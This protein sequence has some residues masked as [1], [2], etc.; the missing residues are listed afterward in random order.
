MQ[1]KDRG[2]LRVILLWTEE[3]VH[4]AV[5]ANVHVEASQASAWMMTQVQGTP[6]PQL[7][8]ADFPSVPASDPEKWKIPLREEVRHISPILTEEIMSIECIREKTVMVVSMNLEGSLNVIMVMTM[9]R[10]I[11]IPLGWLER[12]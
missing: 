12:K 4:P 5:A 2:T 8:L 11:G 6:P 1:D 10:W 3:L 7:Q 9:A